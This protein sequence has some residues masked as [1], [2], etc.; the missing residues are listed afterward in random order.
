VPLAGR[1][2][3]RF[4]LLR[5]RPETEDSQLQNPRVLSRAET[6]TEFASFGA[7][8]RSEEAAGSVRIVGSQLGLHGLDVVAAVAAAD[9]K[10]C[11]GKFASG[12]MSELVDSDV[13]FRGFAMC[14]DSAGNRLPN[15]S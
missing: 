12:R 5:P 13:V 4:N 9:A 11:R 3:G 1:R 15:P 10:E 6:P 14:E 8:W 7:A 2:R